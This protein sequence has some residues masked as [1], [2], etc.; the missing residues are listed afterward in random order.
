MKHFILLLFFSIFGII[1][2]IN[3]KHHHIYITAN[4]VSQAG[5]AAPI[6]DTITIHASQNYPIKQATNRT[7]WLQG[8]ISGT[9][10]TFNSDYTIIIN[11]TATFST[12]TYY[13]CTTQTAFKICIIRLHYTYAL[14]GIRT[15]PCPI[16]SVYAPL[17]IYV[18]TLLL[19][20]APDAGY[21]KDTMYIWG[22]FIGGGLNGDAITNGSW[23]NSN[24][25]ALM[26]NEGSGIY[27]YTIPSLVDWF[28]VTE[29]YLIYT[30]YFG[31]LPK[32]KN[33]GAINVMKDA[34][35][36][37]DICVAPRVINA[38]STPAVAEQ[39]HVFP[40]PTNDFL[41]LDFENAKGANILIFDVIGRKCD[42]QYLA[43]YQ[44]KITTVGLPN[45]LYIGQ[46]QNTNYRF[47]FIKQD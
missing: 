6:G 2:T 12:P 42:S 19:D 37:L 1:N 44:N 21:F 20:R 26:Q 16:Q 46:I 11:N 5:V 24:P 34:G 9:G 25:A 39:I 45:G 7:N 40:N 13:I 31:I 3:A 4:G 29:P 28:Q 14:S 35:V 36:L 27:S 17:K 22:W 10:G 30:G 38:E 18:D 8:N 47:K 41:S 32:Y 15:E 43:S 33:H 23:G